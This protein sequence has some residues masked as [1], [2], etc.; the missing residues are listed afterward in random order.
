MSRFYT[1]KN[2]EEIM[3]RNIENFLK[4]FL[5]KTLQNSNIYWQLAPKL[6]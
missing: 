2:K 5:F 4:L 3:S 6:N 1:E